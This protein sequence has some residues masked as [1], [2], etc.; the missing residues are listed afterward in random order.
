MIKINIVCVGNLKDKFYID[1]AGEYAKRLSRFCTLKIIELKE[2]T[3]FDS[4]LQIK[5]AEGEDI[6]KNLSGYVILMDVKGKLISSEELA[7]KIEDI[8]LNNSEITFVIGGS[9]G[10]SEMVKNRANQIVSVSKMTF[11]HRLFRVM[12]LEQIYRAFMINSGGEYHK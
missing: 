11:P 3:K 5:N 12:L 7:E 8:S 1:G 9:Y 6:I 10:V 2:Q 4:P